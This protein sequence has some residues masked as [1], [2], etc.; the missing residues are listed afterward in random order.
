MNPF[1]DIY[2]P[3]LSTLIFLPNLAYSVVSHFPR[4]TSKCLFLSNGYPSNIPLERP[5]QSL[6]GMPALK[7]NRTSDYIGV[8]PSAENLN[9][10]VVENFET[11]PSNKPN[12]RVTGL[13]YVEGV[14]IGAMLQWQPWLKISAYTRA[15]GIEVA[16]CGR[17]WR[18]GNIVFA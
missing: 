13:I 6:Q 16:Y 18:D 3:N 7:I 5:D 2:H 9:K 15:S 11:Y 17:F 8:R 14:W 4:N 1:Q 12:K 10:P